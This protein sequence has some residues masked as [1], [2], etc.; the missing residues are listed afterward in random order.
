[1]T[2]RP[3]RPGDFWRIDDRSGF[4][5]PASRTRKE[6][7]GEIVDRKS[8]EARHPQDF[9]RARRDEQRVPDPRPR[10]EDVFQFPPG[11]PF[12]LILDGAELGPCVWVEADGE[13]FVYRG[14]DETEP[15]DLPRSF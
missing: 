1:M 12:L 13:V 14:I 11:G 3:T 5:V 15:E 8:Y 10:P 4:K 7:T 9:V 2:K 6:W